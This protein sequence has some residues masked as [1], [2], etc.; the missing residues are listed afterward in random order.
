MSNFNDV[1]WYAI[2]V[3]WQ[4]F[5]DIPNPVGD[6]DNTASVIFDF[7]YA[8]GTGRPD[9]NFAVFDEPEL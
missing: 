1:D 4:N 7:D 9:T 2:D 6:F 8:D 3:D 5:Q